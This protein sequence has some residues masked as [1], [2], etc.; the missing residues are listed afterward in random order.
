MRM[1]RKIKTGVVVVVV[2]ND[3][4]AAT[5]EFDVGPIGLGDG[6]SLFDR[7]GSLTGVRTSGGKLKTFHHSL[8]LFLTANKTFY[9]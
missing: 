6:V 5:I 8:Q 3:S 4:K 9:W 7:I 2:N 1:P